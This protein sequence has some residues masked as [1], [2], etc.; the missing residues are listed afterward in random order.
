MPGSVVLDTSVVVARML[1]PLHSPA[2]I[3]QAQQAR[4]LLHRLR[5]RGAIAFL[6]PTGFAEL[7]HVSVRNRYQLELRSRRADIAARFGSSISSWTALYK[8]DPTIIQS[9]AQELEHIRANLAVANIAL[10]TP[11]DLQ[12]MPSDQSYDREFIRMIGRYAL[13]TSD[14]LILMEAARLG[15]RSIVTMDRDLLRAHEDFDIYTWE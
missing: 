12:Q 2:S 8:L 13:D 6:T 3:R 9:H 7:L 10:A 14:C 11:A 5:T 15:V 4:S 1:N